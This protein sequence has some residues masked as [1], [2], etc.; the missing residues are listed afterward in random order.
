MYVTLSS[1][2]ISLPTHKKHMNS[3]TNW[4]STQFIAIVYLLFKNLD[5]CQ[6]VPAQAYA[7]TKPI[8]ADEIKLKKHTHTAEPEQ[9]EGLH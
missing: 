7:C 9:Q 2:T 4:N 5:W 6:Y 1:C 8:D 3:L